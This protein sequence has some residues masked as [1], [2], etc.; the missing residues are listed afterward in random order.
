MSY[1]EHGRT[2]ALESVGLGLHDMVGEGIQV[3]VT[4][5]TAV[6]RV[7]AVAGDTLVVETTVAETRR[8]RT[9]W[10]QRILRGDD[11]CATLVVTAGV[12]NN[13]G[14]PIKPPPWVFERMG[15]LKVADD[16]AAES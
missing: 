11:V 9:V 5:I 3:V 15:A 10:H 7:P 16:G 4:E 12:T 6:Y 2:E 8:A 14:R 1:F 13:D